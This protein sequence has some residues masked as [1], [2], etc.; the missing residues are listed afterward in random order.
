MASQISPESEQ[1]AMP[2]KPENVSRRRDGGFI[3]ALRDGQRIGRE[4]LKKSVS[5]PLAPLGE[6]QQALF[7]LGETAF[8]ASPRLA[9]QGE[10]RN[11]EA[12]C[13][14]KCKTN[15]EEHPGAEHARVGEGEV[16][17]DQHCHD[18]AAERRPP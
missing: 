4:Q 14:R 2:S 8:S 11:D 1:T 10:R 15:E 7:E 18:G 5:V 13:Q 12:Q 6:G 17:G 9:A 3:R 16:I